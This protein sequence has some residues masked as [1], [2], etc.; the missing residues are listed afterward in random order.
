MTTQ[1][2]RAGFPQLQIHRPIGEGGQKYAYV[3]SLP[4]NRKAALKLIK[5]GQDYERVLREILAAAHFS[6]PR[7]PKI[8]KWG[9]VD[10]GSEKML[11][12]I[13][14]FIEGKNLRQHLQS[15]PITQHR[16]L[17]IGIELLLA[18]EE[19][20][21]RRLVHRDVKPE[22]VMVC[23]ERIV[24]LDFGIA[25][26]LLLNSLTQDA[27][28]FGPLTPGY[29]APEQIRN[30]KRVISQ[31]TDLFAWGIVMY[32]MLAGYNPFLCGCRDPGEALHRTLVYNPPSLS[33]LGRSPDDISDIIVWCLKKA[34]HQRPPHPKVVLVRL[35]EASQS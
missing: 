5:Q 3:V 4:D 6:S 10:I 20:S 8:F 19:I 25:R 28:P 15:H 30:E 14:E 32:E 7:F 24:L 18:I 31:R 12:V 21:E 13:E 29:A 9:D 2:L 35:K 1:T 17:S 26:H 16:S 22:N 27:E 23:G 11:Y 34:A 33:S